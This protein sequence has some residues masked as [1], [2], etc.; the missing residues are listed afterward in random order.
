[1]S[2]S[3]CGVH[4]FQARSQDLTNGGATWRKFFWGV[5]N[6]FFKQCLVWFYSGIWLFLL[7]CL[8]SNPEIASI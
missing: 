6:D 7:Y 1:M 8:K 3:T 4:E 2:L 5:F